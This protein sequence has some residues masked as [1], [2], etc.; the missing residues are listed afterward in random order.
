MSSA[1]RNLMGLSRLVRQKALTSI[2]CWWFKGRFKA[3][4]IAQALVLLVA[5]LPLV[6]WVAEAQQPP[7]PS[8]NQ[9]SGVTLHVLGIAQDAGHPQI[10]C[11]A[12]RCLSAWRG[13]TPPSGATSLALIINDASFFI[14]DAPPELPAAFYRVWRTS[15]LRLEDLDGVFLTHAHMGHYAG[16][17]HLG[18][19]GAGASGIPVYAMPRMKTFLE[20]NAP[21]AQL[22]NDK[23]ITIRALR[24]ERPE[25]F[26]QIT[27]TPWQVPHRDEYSET[28]GYLIQG[29]F[30]NALYLPDI[31][32]WHRWDRGLA[33]VIQQVDFAFID[34]TFFGADELPGRD[35]SLIPHP[36]VESTMALLKDLA[37]KLRQRVIFIHMNNTNPLLDPESAQTQ[38]VIRGGFNIA[39]VGAAYDL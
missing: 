23:N 18:K 2:C 8:E 17:L 27:V 7:A 10:D 3:S 13:E 24:A 22:V 12:P 25:V 19:E 11:Y 33:D 36:T 31:D 6:P 9:S 35:M 26:D 30:K 38:R 5:G 34:A 39:R 37:P 15:Q 16:L 28:A 21:W 29:P 1:Q 14:F 20:T 32:Q 4:H